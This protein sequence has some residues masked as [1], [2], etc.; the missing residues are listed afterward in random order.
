VAI[1]RHADGVD[2]LDDGGVHEVALAAGRR[3][4]RAVAGVTAG[5]GHGHAAAPGHDRAAA[6]ARHDRTGITI[7]AIAAARSVVAVSAAAGAI[8][9]AIALHGGSRADHIAAVAAGRAARCNRI[10][11][12][13]GLAG[14]RAVSAAVAAARRIVAL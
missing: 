12:A 14:S 11:A 6:H 9:L 2:R 8:G 7:G 5:L 4:N 1:G 13:I 10:T 3:G